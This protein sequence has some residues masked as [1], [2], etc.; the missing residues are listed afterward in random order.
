MENT[1]NIARPTSY[2]EHPFDS[3]PPLSEDNSEKKEIRKQIDQIFADYEAL[4]GGYDSGYEGDSDS[5]GE[6]EESADAAKPKSINNGKA[7]K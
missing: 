6:G 1:P 7:I 2:L 4:Y 3:K 5:E